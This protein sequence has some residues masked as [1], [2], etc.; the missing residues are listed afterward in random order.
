MVSCVNVICFIGERSKVSKL[1]K[2]HGVNYQ[3]S[4]GRTPLMYAVVTGQ[5]KVYTK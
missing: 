5:A 1:V 3:D 2:Q 4:K